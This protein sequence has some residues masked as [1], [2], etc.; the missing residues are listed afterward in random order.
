MMRLPTWDELLDVQRDV[1]DHP[2]DQPLFVAGPP[3]SGKTVLAVRRAEMLAAV[4]YPTTLVT[5]NRMLRRLVTLLGPNAR[6]EAR[7]MHSF[8][9]RDYTARTGEQ[10]PP[11]VP[12]GSHDYDWGAMLPMRPATSA[13]SRHLVVDEGQDLPEGFFAYARQYAAGLTVFADENQALRDDRTTLQQIKMAGGL[14]NP[15]LLRDNHRNSPEISRL[16]EHFH[17]GRIPAARVLRPSGQPPRLVPG[18]KLEATAQFIARWTENMGKSVGVVAV[19][20]ETVR[21]MR[22]RL[23]QLLPSRRVDWY[24]SKEQNENSV[25]PL[26]PG[27]T[28]L[29]KE[30]V[31]GQEFDSVFLLELDRLLPCP[32]ETARRV[33]YM[34]CTRA[35]DHL[36]LVPGSRGLSPE[37]EAHLPGPDI[38]ER[39]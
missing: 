33:M 35:R 13:P 7:T 28:V 11:R 18:A 4:P 31:K 20:N 24:D 26:E 2:L 39:G 9:W 23:Q 32:T 5:Y 15:K 12:P 36:V 21:W 37:Q 8:T 16:A 22:S 6:F 3:G 38:L 10:E 1:L 17:G 30:S 14:P 25:N 34:L 29:N 27:C 19:S